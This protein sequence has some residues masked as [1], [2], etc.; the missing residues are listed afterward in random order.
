MVSL[1]ENDWMVAKVADF[2]LSR[3]SAPK[4]ADP[5]KTWQWL[6]PEILQGIEYDHR[7]DVSA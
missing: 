2:G 5:L 3:F 4:V 7:S 1:S 6:A